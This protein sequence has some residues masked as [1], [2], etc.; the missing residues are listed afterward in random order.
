MTPEADDF[1]RV[2]DAA[3]RGDDAAWRDLYERH[4]PAVLGYLRAQRA[5]S[6]EDLLGETWLQA[7]RDLGRF[8]GA[9]GGF[10]SWLLTIAHNR[11]LDA[12]RSASRRPVE[13]NADAA[14]EP[15]G[16]EDGDAVVRAQA[17]EQLLELLDGV[18]ERQRSLLYLRYVL[19]YP[20]RDVARILGVSVPATKML[21][22]RALRSLERRLG[23]LRAATSDGAL[24][25]DGS[26]RLG[27]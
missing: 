16:P 3:R 23:E 5:P 8:D 12:R 21:Q 15:T 1:D 27:E 14:P 9:E 6:P 24:P 7:V 20:Q 26:G 4:A 11:L 10:R 19:D 2:L 25:W 18:P 22:A 13:V 17:Q